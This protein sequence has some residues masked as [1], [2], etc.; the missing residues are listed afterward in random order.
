MLNDVNEN[1]EVVALPVSSSFWVAIDLLNQGLLLH[2]TRSCCIIWL[3]VLL[4]AQKL[5]LIGS[6]GIMP[7]SS[8]LTTLAGRAADIGAWLLYI[9]DLVDVFRGHMIVTTEMSLLL[10]RCCSLSV[11]WFAHWRVFSSSVVIIGPRGSW[12][13]SAGL[14]TLTIIL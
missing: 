9:I 13:L 4:L 3:L 2:L 1:D 14:M 12:D 5:L 8:S 7:T 11:L 6:V 10:W